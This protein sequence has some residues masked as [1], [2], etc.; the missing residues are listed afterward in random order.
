MYQLSCITEIAVQVLIVFVGG[1]A[2]Q[3]T[4]IGGRD[5]GISLALGFVSIPLGALIRLMP[6]EP[7]EKCF[8]RLGLL[9]QDRVLP[10]V[11]PEAE[12]WSGASALV[13]DNLGMFAN[14]RGGR[15]RSSSFVVKSRLMRRNSQDIHKP[16]KAYVNSCFV[17]FISV[18]MTGTV[19]P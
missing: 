2:F 12:A 9:G 3:V 8:K 18:L 13:R 1:A 11:R 17:T 4:R 7:F 5:W 16:L 14:I 6:S 15:V 19:H 10:S